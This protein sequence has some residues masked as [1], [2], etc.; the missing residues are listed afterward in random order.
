MPLNDFVFTEV[1]LNLKLSNSRN[2]VEPNRTELKTNNI[3]TQT[4][5]EFSALVKNSNRTEPLLSLEPEQNRTLAV[6]VLSHL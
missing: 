6:R 4:E 1:Q 3:R 2:H 5:P